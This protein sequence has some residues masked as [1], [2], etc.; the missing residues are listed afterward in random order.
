MNGIL[1]GKIGMTID[2]LIASLEKEPIKS[3][4]EYGLGEKRLKT[5]SDDDNKSKDIN[6]MGTRRQ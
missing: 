4:G 1:D 5:D 2:E 6:S 3:E